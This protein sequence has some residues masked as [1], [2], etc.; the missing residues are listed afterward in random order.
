MKTVQQSKQESFQQQQHFQA[1]HSTPQK[2]SSVID[3]PNTSINEMVDRLLGSS[4]VNTSFNFSPSLLLQFQSPKLNRM[5][6]GSSSPAVSSPLTS[7][8]LSHTDVDLQHLDPALSFGTSNGNQ[9]FNPNEP[10]IDDFV[11]FPPASASSTPLQLTKYQSR[12]FLLSNDNAFLGLSPGGSFLNNNNNNNS[13]N[14]NGNNNNSNASLPENSS[15][16]INN[17]SIDFNPNLSLSFLNFSPFNKSTS[18]SNNPLNNFTFN[19]S[20]PSASSSTPLSA[21]SSSQLNILSNNDSLTSTPLK[22]FLNSNMSDLNLSSTHVNQFDSFETQEPKFIT[23]LKTM[24]NNSTP[25]SSKSSSFAF[26]SVTKSQ[27]K[28]SRFLQQK[29]FTFKHSVYTNSVNNT[30]NNIEVF[31]L[32]N[33]SNNSYSSANSSSSFSASP[34]SKFSSR[35]F[36]NYTQKSWPCSSSSPNVS[37]ISNTSSSVQFSHKDSARYR[38]NSMLKSRLEKRNH[39]LSKMGRGG[40][41]PLGSST[42]FSSNNYS[43]TSS[44]SFSGYSDQSLLSVDSLDTKLSSLSNNSSIHASKNSSALVMPTTQQH[45]PMLLSSQ[46]LLKI[47]QRNALKAKKTNSLVPVSSMGSSEDGQIYYSESDDDSDEEDSFDM[48]RALESNNNSNAKEKP[49]TNENNTQQQTSS[50]ST[51]EI[52]ILKEG[53]SGSLSIESSSCSSISCQDQKSTTTKNGKTQIVSFPLLNKKQMKLKQIE[54]AVVHGTKII[55]TPSKKTNQL[56]D[57]NNENQKE[58]KTSL[59]SPSSCAFL[60][61]KALF[62]SIQLSAHNHQQ[63]QHHH[64]KQIQKPKLDQ[65]QQQPLETDSTSHKV[66]LKLG[67]FYDI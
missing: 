1:T 51:S 32:S 9:N 29:E 19:T 5:P 38:H 65:Q 20:T 14:S 39:N 42:L 21:F 3:E 30:E 67:K 15:N 17:N 18:S 47:V 57:N 45:Q 40:P 48:S 26:S 35:M 24:F 66:P 55:A 62:N 63:Q 2:K 64:Q 31:N 12:P 58:G 13:N 22:K 37:S 46:H 61:A 43:D 56:K 41:S 16:S 49:L 33:V 53:E 36:K 34:N 8:I 27:S 23:P 52:V 11:Q 4:S 59:A 7:R 54:N 60:T 6:F 50:S 44:S 10:F 25:S 28:S